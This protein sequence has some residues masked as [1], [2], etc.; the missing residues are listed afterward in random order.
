M[1]PTEVN[2]CLLVILLV[3]DP[4]EY[5]KSETI[6]CN[7]HAI[8]YWNLVS[9][10][11]FKIQ[12]CVE[13]V[14]ALGLGFCH[15]VATTAHFVSLGYSGWL[16]ICHPRTSPTITT[17]RHQC[18]SWNKLKSKVDSRGYPGLH[19]FSLWTSASCHHSWVLSAL[20]MYNISP[21]FATCFPLLQCNLLGFILQAPPPN[22]F[23][24]C[25]KYESAF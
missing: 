2:H 13:K 21:M 1:I 25:L 14:W 15:R 11:F 19:S 9:T 24:R 5:M 16:W 22:W 12:A 3:F 7:V 6:Y 10:F 20:H 17:P 23:L 18:R 8:L 4:Y